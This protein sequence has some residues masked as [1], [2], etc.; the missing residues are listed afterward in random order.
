M[1]SADRRCLALLT[2][3]F[4]LDRATKSILAGR[5]E[6]PLG[7]FASLQPVRNSGIAFSI[8]VPTVLVT[9]IIGF[10]VFILLAYGVRL[11]RQHR[12]WF[13][14]ALLAV[15]GAANFFDRL[16]HGAVIDFVRVGFLPVFN[17]ADLMI[18]VGLAL[19]MWPGLTR[20]GAKS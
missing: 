5:D 2:I 19:L 15:G 8:P 1:K 20:R 6:I 13:P 10:V 3:L 18:V 17:L 9:L 7:S 16:R 14:W 11:F 12:R 4:A